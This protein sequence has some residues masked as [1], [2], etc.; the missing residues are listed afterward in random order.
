[1]DAGGI[2]HW[3]S[4]ATTGIEGNHIDRSIDEKMFFCTHIAKGLAIPD[5]LKSWQMFK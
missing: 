1:M 4:R 3:W 2:A 5:D